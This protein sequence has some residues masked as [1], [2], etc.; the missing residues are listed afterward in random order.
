MSCE[1]CH[2]AVSGKR[3]E[4]NFKHRFEHGFVLWFQNNQDHLQQVIK[5]KTKLSLDCS[6]PGM[7]YHIDTLIQ[8]EPHHL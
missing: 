4:S 3:N 2:L 7:F 8:N 1:K 5:H 6:P